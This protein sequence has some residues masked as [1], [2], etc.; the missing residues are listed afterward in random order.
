[1]SNLLVNNHGTWLLGCVF[2]QDTGVHILSSHPSTSLVESRHSA[3]E[4]LIKGSI[5][6][7]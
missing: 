7:V 2:R 6:E 1:M 4:E 5:A 3:M